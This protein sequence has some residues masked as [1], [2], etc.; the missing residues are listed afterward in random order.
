[1]NKKNGCGNAEVF[2]I[3]SSVFRRGTHANWHTADFK[4][5]RFC[6]WLASSLRLS[7]RAEVSGFRFQECMICPDTRNLT[8]EPKSHARA[9]F[10]VYC[11]L[12]TLLLLVPRAEAAP[13]QM[14]ITF[15]GYTNRTEE[16][17]N[18]PVLVVFSN[19]VGNGFTFTNFVTANG[20]DLRFYTNE[21]DTGSG[22]NYEIES[23]YTQS[24]S[25]ATD[26]SGC[27]LWLKADA[28]VFTNGS[29]SVTNWLDQ[30]GS[31]NNA[32]PVGVSPSWANNGIGG[33]A[34]VVRF[35]GS[36]TNFQTP[37]TLTT[38][39][40]ST[41]ITVFKQTAETDDGRVWE[42]FTNNIGI[43]G[44]LPRFLYDGLLYQ[45]VAKND[46]AW[47]ATVPSTF[48]I[49]SNYIGT[50]VYDR[51]YSAVRLYS[52]GALNQSDTLGTLTVSKFTVGRLFTG[53]IAE[54]IVYNRTLSA[55]EQN[56]VHNYLAGKYGIQ[57][58]NLPTA[59]NV[60]VQ[61]P[62]IPTNGSGAIW[63]RWGNPGASSQLPC[64]TNGAVWTNGYVAVW[65]MTQ[66]NAQDSTTNRYNGLSANNVS[67]G[68]GYVGAGQCFFDG[69]SLTFPGPTWKTNSFS[70]SCWIK[71]HSL[72]GSYNVQFNAVGGW[73]A[74]L[75]C[76]GNNDGNIYAGIID[77]SAG[78]ME[79]LTGYFSLTN[80]TY[81]TFTDNTNACV[82]FK[83]GGFFSSKTLSA[84]TESWGGFAYGGPY[85]LD[86]ARISSV[87]RSTNWVW[88]EYLNMASNT[89]FNNYGAVETI[90]PP[91]KGTVF[92]MR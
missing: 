80:W 69:T 64:T 68:D 58:Q 10:T 35:D 27:V 56:A 34:A 16:L 23:W 66:T 49:N 28:G 38:P 74:F 2:S 44:F 67:A 9:L 36:V 21:T 18:F 57:V 48:T 51:A 61:V 59:A 30:S 12:F 53:D 92:M 26:I 79:N 7:L 17:T 45:T 14:K 65:H 84:P 60:W 85:F 4:L 83:D 77:T 86:E 52:N 78:R 13:Q 6:R 8:P 91:P 47:M 32:T 42:A 25:A 87:A 5:G 54:V 31:G 41:I 76:N 55:T 70:I 29:G 88:A 71:P 11:S 72:S 22:L 46:T 63:A 50:V 1:M 15:G 20:L 82:L 40:N 43:T 39:V 33:S 73:G 81:F 24:L 3:Q 37:L 90:I 89:V 75:A 19:N 62:L